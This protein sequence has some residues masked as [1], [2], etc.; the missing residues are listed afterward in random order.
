MEQPLAPREPHSRGGRPR[1]IVDPQ[2]IAQYRR[3]GLSFRRI[4]AILQIGDAT[5]RR[6]MR[7]NPETGISGQSSA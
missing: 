7:Q 1:K 3:Q 5:V 6:T 2:L 4:A